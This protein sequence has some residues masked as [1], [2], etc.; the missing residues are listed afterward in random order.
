MRRVDTTQ[1]S[2]VKPI[3]SFTL[4]LILTTLMQHLFTITDKAVLGNIASSTAVASVGVTATITGLTINGFSGLSAGTGIVLARF[5]GEKDREKIKSTIETALVSCLAFG[6]LIAIFG[7][8]LAPTLLRLINCPE[9]CFEGA[10]IYLRIY[11]AAAPAI[12]LYNFGSSIIRTLGDTKRPLHYITLSGIINVVLN[13]ILCFVLPQKVA[14]VAIATIVAK[15]IS[16]LLITRRIFQ[17]DDIVDI[18]LKNVRFHFDAFKLIFR[19]GIPISISNL[20]L[21]LANLQISPAINSFGVDA[22]A[23]NSTASSLQTVISSIS[24]GFGTATATFMGQNIGAKQPERVKKSFWY[25]LA[26]SAGICAAVGTFLHLTGEF[27]IG[28]IIGD[29]SQATLDYGM[30]RMFFLVQFTF[31]DATKAVLG[32][33]LHAYGYPTF[34]SISAILFTLGFRVLW[35]WFIYPLNPTFNMIM[36]CFPISWSLNLLFFTV[37]VFIIGRRYQRG[38]YRK[39]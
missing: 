32:R 35:M 37:A 26:F 34:G 11:I 19:F 10:V 17:M 2:L 8:S 30:A 39:I 33:A 29:P 1:G 18:S 27:W 3:L 9:E 14:A 38:I 28:L 31:I 24:G 7:V 13:L 22:V 5:V 15:I 25:C 16:A 20:L 23:G 36:L 12:M 6:V 21:P 4:P